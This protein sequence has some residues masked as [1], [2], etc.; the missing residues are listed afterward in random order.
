MKEFEKSGFRKIWTRRD[1]FSSED[2]F[3]L[4]TTFGFPF[5]EMTL[6]LARERGHFGGRSRFQRLMDEHKKLSRGGSERK[7]KGGLCRYVRKTTRFPHTAHH[8][9]GKGAPNSARPA[10]EA[11]REQHYAG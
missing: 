10:G 3:V 11:A 5:F 1:I 2:A 4:F 8:L 6:E 9:L 7:F